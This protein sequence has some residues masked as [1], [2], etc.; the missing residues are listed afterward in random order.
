M[1][2]KFDNCLFVHVPKVAGQ[3]VE[4][5]FL[6]RAGLS[7][8]QRD[9]FLLKQNKQLKLG[10]PRLAHLTASEY[11]KLGYVTQHEFDGLYKFSFVRNPWERILSEYQYRA[12]RCSFKDFLL[13]QFPTVKDDNY[14]T[15]DDLYRH[16]IP[17]AE[18]V[19]DKQGKLMVDF[20]GRFE[21]LTKDFAKVSNFIADEPLLLP[22]KNKTSLSFKRFLQPKSKHYSDYYCDKTEQFVARYY[23]QDIELF[24]YSF[25]S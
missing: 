15:G 1:I 25:D 23:A 20:I 2:S 4:S 11:I 21:K 16:V 12:Y 10:P 17:Q 13:K 24:N 14:Y 3:S 22:H 5:V 9:A 8:H 6:K 18:F 19:C 7:W